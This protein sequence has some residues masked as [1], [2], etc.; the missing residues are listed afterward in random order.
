M[1]LPYPSLYKYTPKL[2]SV[3]PVGLGRNFRYTKV[4]FLVR[5]VGRY[6]S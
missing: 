2:G 1:F 3:I 6:S 5:T 4:T